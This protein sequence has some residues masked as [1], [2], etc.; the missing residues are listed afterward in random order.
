MKQLSLGEGIYLLLYVDDLLIA[1]KSKRREIQS[2]KDGLKDEFEMK[3]LGSA[4]RI[5][6]IDIYHKR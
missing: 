3:D 4:S 2:L 6:G 1:A 5:L